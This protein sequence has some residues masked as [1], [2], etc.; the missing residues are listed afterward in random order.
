M[1]QLIQLLEAT[2]QALLR[3][4]SALQA[5]VQP[6][7]QALQ[8]QLASLLAGGSSGGKI[9]PT[10]PLA[11]ATPELDSIVLFGAGALALAGLARRQRRKGSS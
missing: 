8:A 4:P 3:L 11:T 2:L 10:D 6:T 1:E 7:I 9:Q 5:L